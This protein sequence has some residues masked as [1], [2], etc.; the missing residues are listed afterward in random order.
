MGDR[1]GQVES[2]ERQKDRERQ[3]R[4]ERG[5]QGERGRGERVRGRTYLALQALLL[6][7]KDGER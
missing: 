1:E 2:L 6:R 5:G 7:L 4:G 3:S